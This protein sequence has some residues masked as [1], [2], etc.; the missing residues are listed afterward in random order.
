VKLAYENAERVLEL[1][2]REGAGAE[3]TRC[4]GMG[5]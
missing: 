4:L 5:L 1:V 3:A 2:A